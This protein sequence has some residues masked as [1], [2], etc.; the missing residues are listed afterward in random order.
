MNFEKQIYKV[1]FNNRCIIITN[2]IN[3]IVP[4]SGDHYLQYENED[5]FKQTVLDFQKHTISS[6]DMYVYTEGD[7][8]D[9]MKILFKI[10]LHVPASGG[11]V[12]N[13]N[14]EVLLIYRFNKWDLP[15][16]HVEKD[17]SFYDAAKREVIEETGV[18]NLEI[19]SHLNS[20]FHVYKKDDNFCIKENQWFE[21]ECFDS[22]ELVP[23]ASEAIEQAKWFKVDELNS[24]LFKMYPSLK[25]LLKK[26]LGIR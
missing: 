4:K 9:L 20:T 23:Q 11:V 17:E 5:E 2:D 12:R 6:L 10:Y 13:E 24:V 7:A 3:H 16:G 14:E 18:K 8:W 22:D 1:F 19:L 25:E 26:Y 21:M 15:K